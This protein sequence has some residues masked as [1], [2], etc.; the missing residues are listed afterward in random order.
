MCTS[1]YQVTQRR[2]GRLGLHEGKRRSTLSLLRFF[3][4]KKMSYSAAFFFPQEKKK[5]KKGGRGQFSV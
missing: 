4:A 1:Q 5:K 3:F 2:F